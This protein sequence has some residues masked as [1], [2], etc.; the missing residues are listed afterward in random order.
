LTP[1]IEKESDTV[2]TIY[3]HVPM[4]SCLDKLTTHTIKAVDVA[5]IGIRVRTPTELHNLFS[6]SQ[7]K[8]G[9]ALISVNVKISFS[10]IPGRFLLLCRDSMVLIKIKLCPFNFLLKP[11]V[12][13]VSVFLVVTMFSPLVNIKLSIASR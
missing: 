2:W 11:W 12:S 7:S 9:K 8:T 6:F 5:Q 10:T 13:A 4:H 3:S 1:Q